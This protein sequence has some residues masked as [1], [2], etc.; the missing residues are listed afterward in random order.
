[1]KVQEQ[2]A[3]DDPSGRGHFICESEL[4]QR[5]YVRFFTRQHGYR[6]LCVAPPGCHRLDQT[7]IAHERIEIKPGSWAASR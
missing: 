4:D 1:V 6:E 3:V 5:I 2:K 7:A